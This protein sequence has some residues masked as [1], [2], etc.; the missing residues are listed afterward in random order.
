M[1]H[2]Y[3]EPLFPSLLKIA[4]TSV[5]IL[6]VGVGRGRMVRLLRAHGISA[7][8]YS[9]DVVP[10]YAIDSPGCGVLE[11]ARAL[12]FRNG[13]FD[14][15]YSLGVVEHFPETH[16]SI[17][18]NARVTKEGGYVLI[19]SH[20][21]GIATLVWW[22][23]YYLKL[24]KM[25]RASFEVVLGRNLRLAEIKGACN[26][27]GLETVE[28][29]ASDPIIPSRSVFLQRVLDKIPLPPRKFMAYLYYLAQKQAKCKPKCAMFDKP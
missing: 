13:S 3:E 29:R 4:M 20:H 11:D 21:F 15:T 2:P 23:L 6:E 9:I 22:L 18:E 8:F 17:L 7:R 26:G 24:R 10:E 1:L 28:V 25:H 16:Q 27:A 14:L 12:P 19:T 5:R